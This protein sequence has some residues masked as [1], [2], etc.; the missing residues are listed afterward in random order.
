MPGNRLSRHE[1]IRVVDK[2]KGNW[3][4]QEVLFFFILG[5]CHKN[6]HQIM[7]QIVVAFKL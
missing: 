6:I 4:L 1:L 7:F 3:M 2:T 5:E